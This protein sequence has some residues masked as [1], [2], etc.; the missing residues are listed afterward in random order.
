MTAEAPRDRMHAAGWYTGPSSCACSVSKR[1]PPLSPGHCR[2]HTQLQGVTCRPRMQL[3][4]KQHLGW[5]KGG[6]GLAKLS[7]VKLCCATLPHCTIANAGPCAKFTCACHRPQSW[8]LTQTSKDRRQH[9]TSGDGKRIANMPASASS[10]CCVTRICMLDVV[11]RRC[12][13][14]Y[15]RQSCKHSA[16]HG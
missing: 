8:L 9:I 13:P 11:V 3:C 12:T 6:S 4:R 14:V 5:V 2:I 10:A 16:V 1:G 15:L 7:K